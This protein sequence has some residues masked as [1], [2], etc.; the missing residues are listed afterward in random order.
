MRKFLVLTGLLALFGFSVNLYA[1]STQVK[2]QVV[3]AAGIPLIAVTVY[4][5]GNTTIGTMTD[6]DG[7]YVITPSSP[8]ATL[9]FSCMG[10]AEVK[11]VIGNREVINVTLHEEQ[12]SIDAAEVVSVGYG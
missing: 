9:V 4:Q 1:Q 8:Q 5:D 12:L 7:N 11:E 10:F 3:D 6:L 2:G